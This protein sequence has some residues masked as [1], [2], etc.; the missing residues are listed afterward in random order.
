MFAAPPFQF[1]KSARKYSRQ[2][3]LLAVWQKIP[4]VSFLIANI[5]ERRFFSHASRQ[6][7]PPAFKNLGFDFISWTPR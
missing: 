7:D 3:L 2:R 6:G 1:H 5:K 4:P